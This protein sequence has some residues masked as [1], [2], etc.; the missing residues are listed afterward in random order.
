MTSACRREREREGWVERGSDGEMKQ[1][2]MKAKVEAEFLRGQSIITGRNACS[3]GG[4]RNAFT[5]TY[6]FNLAI[7]GHFP[8]AAI[9]LFALSLSLFLMRYCYTFAAFILMKNTKALTFSIRLFLQW[10]VI[11]RRAHQKR[12]H[13]LV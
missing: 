10:V 13:C 1:D 11:S 12:K 6:Y 9:S 5:S 8:F 2:E 4:H 7:K 3:S